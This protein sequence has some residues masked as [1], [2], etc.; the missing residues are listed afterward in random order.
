MSII[1]IFPDQTQRIW[2]TA[3]QHYKFQYVASVNTKIGKLTVQYHQ[4]CAPSVTGTMSL[5][6]APTV[7]SVLLVLLIQKLTIRLKIFVTYSRNAITF[8]T[9]KELTAVIDFGLV[10]HVTY[11][12]F[13]H[14]KLKNKRKQECKIIY[15]LY[16]MSI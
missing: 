13:K 8:G 12:G 14:Y 4:R 7:M 15:K 3:R 9:M 16:Y 1:I 11:A 5:F 2:A 6:S 10:A